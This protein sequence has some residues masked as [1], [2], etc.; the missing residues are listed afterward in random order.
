ML[1]LYTFKSP[2]DTTKT[3]IQT[4]ALF[5][6][7]VFICTVGSRNRCNGKADS[8]NVTT[9]RLMAKN[10]MHHVHRVSQN[11]FIINLACLELCGRRHLFFFYW[12]CPLIFEQKRKKVQLF[13]L[14][15]SGT[16]LF[17][18]PCWIGTFT[19]LCSNDINIQRETLQRKQKTENS[20][21]KGS[22]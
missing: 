4:F 2:H 11:I 20:S 3:D 18:A 5:L 12:E 16:S 19:A 21:S 10:K 22:Q 14:R 6:F 9:G 7:P 1:F 17:S 13:V 8:N 15:L